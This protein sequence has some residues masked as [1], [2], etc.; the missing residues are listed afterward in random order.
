MPEAATNVFQLLS[1]IVAGPPSAITANNYESAVSLL[2]TFATAGSIGAVTEQKRDRNARKT[3]S[4]KQVNPRENEVVSRAIKAVI[5]VY[6]LTNRV[7]SLIEQSHLERNEAWTTYW[8]PIFRALST[9]CINPCREIRHQ[10][11]SGLQRA[12]LSPELASTDHLEWTAIF[13]E[14]LFP[15]IKRLLK[16]EI[17]QSDPI[18]MSETRVQAATLLCK[19]FLHYLVL[20][21]EWEGMLE[22]WLRILDIMDRLMNSGQGDSLVSR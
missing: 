6:Q 20:L 12:L 18:G 22:L 2:N 11:F 10:A 7:P 21:S 14:V 16:P 19:I 5:M 3:N 9:Q 13:G 17:Y 8:S 1:G 4:G 15:L